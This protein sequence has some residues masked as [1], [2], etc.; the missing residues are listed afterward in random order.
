MAGRRQAPVIS[1]C[2]WLIDEVAVQTWFVAVVVVALAGCAA[3]HAAPPVDTSDADLVL[4][5]TDFAFDPSEPT[6]GDG[7]V[8]VAIDNQGLVPHAWVVEGMEDQLRLD[9]AADQTDRGSIEL[10]P[11][12]NLFYCDIPGHRAAGME[13]TVTVE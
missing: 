2:D 1:L 7:E 11:G 3:G 6:V 13:G 4:T 9:T 8:T 5:A 12:T 10:D